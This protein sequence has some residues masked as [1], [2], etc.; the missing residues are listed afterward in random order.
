MLPIRHTNLLYMLSYINFIPH[1]CGDV[2][3]DARR[4]C[5]LNALFFFCGV[6]AQ[7]VVV[8]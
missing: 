4:T 6:Y 5:S 8:W 3:R 2:W 1:Y 7:C